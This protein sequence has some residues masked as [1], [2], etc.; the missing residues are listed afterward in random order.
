MWFYSHEWSYLPQPAWSLKYPYVCNKHYPKTQEIDWILRADGE[1][2]WEKLPPTVRLRLH[3]IDWTC[4][5]LIKKVSICTCLHVRVR[6]WT[7]E[8]RNE[9]LSVCARA[10]MC[11]CVCVCVC[12]CERERERERE[13]ENDKVSGYSQLTF[14]FPYW[15]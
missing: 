2:E 6:E 13:R 4:W 15:V 3:V 12:V 1:E 7:N 14:F 11:V 5:H 8:W 9:W 10:C